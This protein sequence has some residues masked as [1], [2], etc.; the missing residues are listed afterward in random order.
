[1]RGDGRFDQPSALASTLRRGTRG[2][3]SGRLALVVACAG[4]AI[5]CAARSVRPATDA[6]KA[7]PD[8][9]YCLSLV[10]ERNVP[11]CV[12]E[13]TPEQQKKSET[14]YR[15]VLAAGKVA[16]VERINGLGSPADDP[17][18]RISSEY[19]YRDGRVSGV[20]EKDASGVI[21]RRSA[22]SDDATE[23][24]WLDAEGRPQTEGTALRNRRGPDASGVKQTFDAHG[25][26]A[27]VA[28]INAKGEPATSA[29]AVSEVRIVRDARGAI[30][31]ETYFDRAGQPALNADGVH[32]VVHSPD[33]L[34]QSVLDRYLDASGRPT[35]VEH[36]VH[37]VRRVFDGVGNL[38]EC[39]YQYTDGRAVR[40]TEDGAAMYRIARDAH[41]AEVSRTYFDEFGKPIESAYGYVTQRIGRNDNGV[42]TEWRYVD[43]DGKPAAL[44]TAGYSIKRRKVDEHG[45]TLS[46]SFFD[47]EERPA[48]FRGYHQVE[49]S[50]DARG[51][52]NL[53]KYEDA[54]GNLIATRNGYAMEH[55]EY[56]VDR[57][58]LTRYVDAQDRPVNPTYMY[59]EH[60]VYYRHKIVYDELGEISSEEFGGVGSENPEPAPPP[61]PNCDHD[62]GQPT[63][64]EQTRSMLTQLARL[65]D[66][67]MDAPAASEEAK[68][69]RQL[70]MSLSTMKR[71]SREVVRRLLASM[72]KRA[73]ACGTALAESIQS[74]VNGYLQH[75]EEN[76]DK[77]G[78]FGVGLQTA[79]GAPARWI[80]TVSFGI[81]CG[82][83]TS[84]YVFEERE[85]GPVLE[86]AVEAA[87]LRGRRRRA[88]GADREA[89]SHRYL[90][91]FL[92]GNRPCNSPVRQRR[93]DGP[94]L[95]GIRSR[96]V[97]RSSDEGVRRGIA[98]T[99]RNRRRGS[100]RNVR[101]GICDS[102]RVLEHARRVS[103]SDAR[104]ELCSPRGQVRARSALHHRCA[105]HARRVDTPA[106]ACR[107]ATGCCWDGRRAQAVARAHPHGGERKGS[108]RHVGRRRRE[109]RN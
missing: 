65:Q 54:H 105:K 86:M 27:T 84:V 19:E 108:G 56:D 11:T 34:G 51:N 83:D 37:A 89:F 22:V 44:R 52:P 13:L 81:P 101:V 21:R 109:R 104:S 36:R 98:D 85:K 71:L 77:I 30:T 40:S 6:A 48:L 107:G 91:T 92:P 57:L 43:A 15:L 100:N 87:V 8:V 63:V 1:M 103:G 102:V 94:H 50:Y 75:R 23:I 96:T 49:V 25:R 58:V 16:R 24:R 20:V 76:G 12:Q 95:S 4:V 31:D 97:T 10:T 55:R 66:K 88:D 53:F 17:P 35:T 61:E 106:L 80:S 78:G 5:A 32:H 60:E 67:A 14:A 70:Q 62:A 79:A 69:P 9:R 39:S 41:G 68:M 42:P 90:G 3:S 29:D 45:R 82:S 74:T 33:R 72:P 7:T 59:P 99:P 26:V 38:L 28:Y 18:A 2:R 46:E 93:M 73:T 64:D 47:T